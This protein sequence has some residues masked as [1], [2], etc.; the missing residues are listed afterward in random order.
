MEEIS[1]PQPQPQPALQPAGENSIL[2]RLEKQNEEILK[3]AR[4]LE[5][6]LFWSQVWGFIKLLVIVIPLVVGLFL[7]PP[8][9]KQI[10]APYQELLEMGTN[11][12][13]AITNNLDIGALLKE[14]KIT[15]Q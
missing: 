8:L 10:L 2:E 1:Q 4:K 6:H 3:I 15:P 11:P 7:L 14:L 12:Q 13:A 9:I 5:H